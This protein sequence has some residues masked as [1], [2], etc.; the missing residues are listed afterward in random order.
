MDIGFELRGIAGQVSV[1]CSRNDRPELVGSAPESAGFP[2]CHA[3]VDY[4][5]QGYD[6]VLGWVQL[7]RSDDNTSRGRAFEV[8]PLDFL[9]DVPHPFCWIGL[10]PRLFD[11]PSRTPRLDLDWVAHSFLCVP[12]AGADDRVEVHA[13]LGF[14]WGFRIRDETV[15][16]VAP[17]RL[18]P[19]E[20]DQDVEVLAGRYPSWRFVDGFRSG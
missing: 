7:V 12:D 3:T 19:A 17:S 16:L 11:A 15:Q 14:S 20:W 13:L 10:S 6:A 4:P 2:F 8:D 18:R 1:T 9:G 5:A